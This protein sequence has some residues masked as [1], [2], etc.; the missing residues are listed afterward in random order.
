MKTLKDIIELYRPQYG[1][2]VDELF[3]G[4]LKEEK[5]IALV[6]PFLPKNLTAALF[7]RGPEQILGLDIFA[8]AEEQN[9]QTI[10]GLKSHYFLDRSSLIAPLILPL[11]EGDNVL[12]MC[13]APGGK[14]LVMLSRGIKNINFFANDLS[15][16][17]LRRLKN[18]IQDYVPQSF[19][20]NHI[21][22]SH[23]DA[24]LFGV[25]KAHY[26][27]AILLDTPCSS[28]AH[29]VQNKKLR[30]QFKGLRK[31]L[32]MRQYSLACS[33]LL[34]L[35]PGG[36]MVYATCSINKNE[37]DALIE[38]LLLKKGAQLELKAINSPLGENSAYGLSILPHKHAAGPAFVSLL[39]KKF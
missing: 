19:S 10:D 22:L 17:R 12:D 16:T 27:D 37:N 15:Q 11:K 1:N 4:L 5:K 25:K 14:L 8:N 28:E 3:L 32:L 2:E 34:S 29:V 36:Y 24:A 39:R 20:N 13:S 9:I 38:R 30:E 31:S 26:F 18:V 6:N 35:K 23:Y 33:A 21:K 7:P